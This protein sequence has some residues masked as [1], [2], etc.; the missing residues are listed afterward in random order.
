MEPHTATFW[1]RTSLRRQ[2]ILIKMKR[3]RTFQQDN[4][5]KHTANDTKI[6]VAN[7]KIYVLQW[8]SRS[9]DLNPI[10]NLWRELK[11]RV[12]ARRPSNPNQLK[13]ICEEEWSNIPAEVCA[14]LGGRNRQQRVFY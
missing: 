7:K 5:L 4:D 2:R 9:P 3:G 8:P 12:N 10:E 6:W 1:P 14:N 13:Q 11:M